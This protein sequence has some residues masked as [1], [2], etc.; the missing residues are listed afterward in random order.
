[1]NVFV[2][3]GHY[4]YEGDTLIL[5]TTNRETATKIQ[6]ETIKEASYNSVEIQEWN[7]ELELVITSSVKHRE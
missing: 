4:D 6:D 2:V 5:I 3:L 7:P 1:M